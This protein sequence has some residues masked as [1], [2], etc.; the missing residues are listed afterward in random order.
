[1]KSIVIDPERCKRD[2]L[3]AAVCPLKLIQFP[4]PENVPSPVAGAGEACI[5]CGHC[6]AVCPHG[7]ITLD[8]TDP[9]YCPPVRREW[10]LDPERTEQFLRSRRTV[11]EY[12]EET[13]DRET[14]LS[15]IHI[16]RY[17]PSAHNAQ[18]AR[19]RVIYDPTEVQRMAGLVVDWMRDFS[20]R[21][22]RLARTMHLGLL[23]AAW[24]AGMDVICW[25]APHVILT[26]APENDPAAARDCTIALTYLDLA[27]PS[28]GLGTCWAG[29][30]M[31][32]AAQWPPMQEALAFPAGHIT[33]GAM[34]LGRSKYRYARLPPRKDPDISWQ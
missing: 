9:E 18:R 22:P 33:T 5:H 29:Y 27:A 28:F 34:M 25:E 17:A 1:M 16:A 19:W 31:R 2:G 4:D 24:E 10:A 14:I 20:K 12:K 21:E 23:T 32:A 7:A 13:V 6:L 8:G 3:C 26:H 30:F 15:L 11:R